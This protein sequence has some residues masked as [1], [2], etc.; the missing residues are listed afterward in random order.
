MVEA[1]PKVTDSA[2]LVT[3]HAEAVLESGK[4]PRNQ[5]NQL[6]SA[7]NRVVNMSNLWDGG[8]L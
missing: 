7:Q 8:Q 2:G 5:T 3:W 6:S 1:V 4:V